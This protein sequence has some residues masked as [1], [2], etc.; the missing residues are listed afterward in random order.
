MIFNIASK[1]TEGRGFF[2]R[3]VHR[4]R[5][6]TWYW[7]THNTQ[8]VRQQ[9]VE[10]RGHHA[11]REQPLPLPNTTRAPTHGVEEPQRVPT[12]KPST[13]LSCRCLHDTNS[14][15]HRTVNEFGRPPYA[16]VSTVVPKPHTGKSWAVQIRTHSKS[17]FTSPPLPCFSFSSFTP[18]LI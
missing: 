3:R 12:F 17:V 4:G 14:W 15:D 10:A 8:H 16:I 1:H 9:H 18:P 11:L 5:T 2:P 6:D 7:L 13:S